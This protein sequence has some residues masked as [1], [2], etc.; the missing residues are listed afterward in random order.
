MNFSITLSNNRKSF[1]PGDVIEGDVVYF[2]RDAS[3]Q[4]L[5]VRLIWFTTGKGDR[6]V[7]IVEMTEIDCTE[8]ITKGTQSFRFTAPHRPLTFSGKLIALTWAIE[9]VAFP[10]EQT[11]LCELTIT[12]D[13][14]PIRLSDQSAALVEH[15]LAQS[16]FKFT[17]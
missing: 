6:D 11:D 17:K 15:K 14:E 10:S 9:A 3:D 8:G 2:D 4:T 16:W 5:S 12:H 1:A 7:E 13:G